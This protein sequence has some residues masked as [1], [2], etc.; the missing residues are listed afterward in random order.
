MHLW[1]ILF[2][3]TPIKTTN[4]R[5][6][7]M[8]IVDIRNRAYLVTLFFVS[9]TTAALLE[10]LRTTS[11]YCGVSQNESARTNKQK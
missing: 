6:E 8:K 9:P 10:L 2:I 4:I 3:Q 11:R 7:T 1:T 5:D